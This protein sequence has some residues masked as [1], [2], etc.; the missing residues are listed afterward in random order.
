[1]PPA[2]AWLSKDAQDLYIELG[3]LAH[4]LGVMAKPHAVALALAAEAM[5][6]YVKLRDEAEKVEAVVTGERG[7]PYQHPIIGM[8]N[9]AWKRVLVALREFG[10]TPTAARSV[11]TAADP[12]ASSPGSR[13]YPL[14]PRLS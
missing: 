9:A 7:A 10:L 14:G 2:P 3:S 1:M 12:E 11:T 6:D 8:R 4:G 5:A 13:Q